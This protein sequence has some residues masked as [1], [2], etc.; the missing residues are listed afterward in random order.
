MVQDSNPGEFQCQWTKSDKQPLQE[1]FLFF[2]RKV[3]SKSL[4]LSA[5]NTIFR[6]FKLKGFM[7]NSIEAFPEVKHR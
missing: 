2:V 7:V 4:K 6:H 1:T 3:R 5:N